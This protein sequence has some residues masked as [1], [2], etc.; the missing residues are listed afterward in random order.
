MNEHSTRG[1]FRQVIRDCMDLF[2]LQMQLISVDSQEARRKATKAIVLGGVAAGLGA[3]MLTVLMIGT[4]FLLH[5]NTDLSIGG[6]LIAT[7][8]A[9]GILIVLLSWI[10]IRSIKTAAAAMSETKSE[11][12]ENLRYLKAVLVSPDSSPRNQLRRD[13]FATGG[14]SA[15]KPSSLHSSLYPSR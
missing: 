1:G 10:A 3:S 7:G 9:V 4:G 15:G 13:T 12:A 6:A 2:E 14:A 8:G 5:E 11:F